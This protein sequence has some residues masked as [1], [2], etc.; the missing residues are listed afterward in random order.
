MVKHETKKFWL[1]IDGKIVTDNKIEAYTFGKIL[2][3][4]QKV[5]DVFKQTKYDAHPKTDFRLYLTNVSKGSVA[6]A[7]Q[8]IDYTTELFKES[9]VFD[10]M[11]FDLQSLINALIENPDEFRQKIELDFEDPSHI[12]RFLESFRGMLSKKNKFSVKVGYDIRKPAKPVVLP[13]H[14]EAYIEDLILEYYRKSAIE[15]KGVIIRIKGDDPRSF[16]IK[17]LENESIKCDYPADWEKDVMAFFKSSVTVK[18]V[19]SKRARLK[20]MEVI[21]DIQPFNS[22]T[23]ESL[24]EFVFRQPLAIRVSFDEKDDHW[25]LANEELSLAGYGSTYEQAL[26]SLKESLESLI[27]GYLAFD[28]A[29]LSEK[30]RKI[31]RNLQ[32][33]IALNDYRQQLGELTV[34]S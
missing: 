24:E 32:T 33:Y 15:I 20:E 9:L 13:S 18:G 34:E 16:T 12:I 14:R 7:F 21:K 4:L 1:I 28:D 8:P 26:S 27:V 19:M 6:V 10:E 5:V 23:I 17:T 3:N 11:V 31:K 2:T 29:A 22:I 25:C 30:S